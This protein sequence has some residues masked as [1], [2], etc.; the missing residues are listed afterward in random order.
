M[1]VQLD[2]KI[3]EQNFSGATQLYTELPVRT[4]VGEVEISSE[5]DGDILQ[6]AMNDVLERAPYFADALVEHNG[7]FFYAENPLPMEVT[8]GGLR[9]TGGPETNYHNIDVTYEG[10]VMSFSMNHG[11]CDGQGLNLFIEAVIN[12]YF[13]RKDGVD[14]PAGGLRVP[15]QPVLDGEEADGIAHL[16]PMEPTP[17]IE[18]V[19]AQRYRKSYVLPEAAGEHLG[20]MHVMTVHVPVDELVGF[21]RSCGSSPAPTL[22]T[23]MAQTVFSVHPEC[24]E[25]VLAII[26]ASTR[27]ALGVPNTFKNAADG[28][29]VY[30]DQNDGATFAERTNAAREALRAQVAPDFLRFLAAGLRERIARTQGMHSFAEKRKVIDITGLGEPPIFVDY[31]DGLR[32]EGF[33]DQVVSFRYLASPQR[34]NAECLGLM[35]T[36]INGHF[37]LALNRS[38]ATDVYDRAFITTLESHGI[39]FER[40][41]ESTYLSPRNGLITALGLA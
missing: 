6:N 17:E 22:A 12:R 1:A 33:E 34:D 30:F 18:A 14:Y 15:G 8:K 23:L 41:A 37:D 24:D 28:T 5:V 39:P 16:E 32:A 38:F 20:H 11:L 7:D 25:P 36:V 9:T 29:F 13:S 21:A 19:L 26:P 2:F 3:K 35:A 4:Y 27:D 10:K 40:G 31:I